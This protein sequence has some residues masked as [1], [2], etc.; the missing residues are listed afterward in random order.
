MS[1]VIS[2]IGKCLG[3]LAVM[4][5]A[6]YVAALPPQ[7]QAVL[8]NQ[9]GF[10]TDRPKRFTAPGA[11]DGA[12]FTVV[13]RDGTVRFHGTIQGGVGDFSDFGPTDGRDFRVVV[14]GAMGGGESVP[15]GIGP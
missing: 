14:E 15:F 10:N 6:A 8:L 4:G 12:R 1:I 13:G 7:A 3:V 9:S 11:E 5:T 2:Q